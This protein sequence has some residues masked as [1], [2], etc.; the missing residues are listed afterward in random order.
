MV[1][2]QGRVGTK[3]SRYEQ[4]VPDSQVLKFVQ[5]RYDESRAA[6]ERAKAIL[7]KNKL[8]AK[9]KLKRDKLKAAKLKTKNKKAK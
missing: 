1:V 5:K 4:E 2:W 8:K 9:A 6:K 7:K 3:E